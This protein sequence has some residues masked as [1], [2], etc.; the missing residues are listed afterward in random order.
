MKEYLNFLLKAADEAKAEKERW[1]STPPEGFS[2]EEIKAAINQFYGVEQA[3]R[4]A[5]NVLPNSI[6]F[7]AIGDYVFGDKKE[8]KQL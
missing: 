4:M 6:T 2:E 3:Y 5:F 1:K 7:P 8:E